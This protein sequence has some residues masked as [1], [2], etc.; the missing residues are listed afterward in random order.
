MPYI[1]I[2]N[3][4]GGMDTRRMA[5]AG[6]PGTLLE[7]TNAHITRGGEIE[8]RKAYSAFASLPSGT[9]GLA[10]DADGLIVFGSGADPG[11]PAG[12]TYQ[13]LQH[14]DGHNMTRLRS[15]DLYAGKVYAAAEFSNGDIL[16]FYDGVRAEDWFD[17]KARGVFT[18]AGTRDGDL[19]GTKSRV[20]IPIDKD[21]EELRLRLFMTNEDDPDEPIDLT[22]GWVNA[23]PSDGAQQWAAAI[24]SAVDSNSSDTGVEATTLLVGGV[25]LQLDTVERTVDLDGLRVWAEVEELNIYKIAPRSSPRA[26]LCVAESS[27]TNEF[28]LFGGASGGS[29]PYTY[30]WEVLDNGGAAS[31]ELSD[32]TA[33]TPTLTVTGSTASNS[34][35]EYPVSIRCTVTDDVGSELAKTFVVQ[36]RHGAPDSTGPGLPPG[37]PGIDFQVE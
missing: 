2:E 29:S 13:R 35:A 15:W 9:R 10:R 7:L 1:V 22:D 27:C 11:V 20:T 25:L 19:S 18:V 3:F 21:N 16:H 37:P 8:K 4:N 31:A 24:K 5:A 33:E 34:Y 26:A 30:L 28:T 32:D 14:P 36:S 17:G 6:T 23:S 12:I